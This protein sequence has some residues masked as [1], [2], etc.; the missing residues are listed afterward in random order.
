[1]PTYFRFG[2]GPFRFS[3]RLGRTQGQ[4]RAA[5]KARA[6]R[7]YFQQQA[8]EKADRDSR[9]FKEVPAHDVVHG[10]G[11]FTSFILDPPGFPQ[12][13][14]K[15]ENGRFSS[16]GILTEDL[17]WLREGDR[18]SGTIGS[19]GHSLESLYGS[20]ADRHRYTFVGWAEDIS[21]QPD[22]STTFRVVF[23]ANPELVWHPEGREPLTVTLQPGEK[24]RWK[25]GRPFRMREGSSLT[26]KIDP[27][28]GPPT[29]YHET[30]D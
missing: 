17:T 27:D 29:I 25:D 9:T 4:K 14:V 16:G 26:V 15:L 18:V 20:L 5:A 13:V 19:D 1:M 28:G 3:Q 8:R 2:V 30:Y 23:P 7:Q 6:E 24:V 12:L 22:G 11:G 21:K 10:E